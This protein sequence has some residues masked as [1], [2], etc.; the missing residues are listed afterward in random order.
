[1]TTVEGEH[2]GGVIAI[3]TSQD[4][5][6]WNEKLEEVEKLWSAVKKEK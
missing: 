4:V 6:H 5:Q 1:M 3:Y 2:Q